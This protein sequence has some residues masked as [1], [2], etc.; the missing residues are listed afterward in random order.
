M[1]QNSHP[2][3]ATPAHPDLILESLQEREYSLTCG[4][5]HYQIKGYLR[6]SETAAEP[7]QQ[8]CFLHGTGFC[9]LTL[10]AMASLLPESWQLMFLDTPG[11]GGSTRPGKGMPDWQEMAQILGKS[12]HQQ[13]R[14]EPVVG[15]GHSMGGILLLLAAVQQPALFSRIV[16]LDPVLFS[17]K[18]IC[19]QRVM[20]TTGLWKFSKLVKTV[21]KRRCNWPDAQTMRDDLSRKSL[22]QQ[23]HPQALQD[24]IKGGTHAVPGGLQLNC[25]PGWESA[26]FGSFPRGLWKAVER[27]SIPVD[28]IIAR[29]SYNFISGSARRAAQLNV[30]ISCHDFGHSHCFPMEQPEETAALLINIIQNTGLRSAEKHTH[31]RL[32]SFLV[33]A[34]SNSMR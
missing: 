31:N 5:H 8:L 11:H 4:K 21:S 22:Y 7:K 27:T 32:K 29:K 25:N 18:I 26:I 2:D 15:V 33:R 9:G 1:I 10:A 13:S 19:W 24:F 34:L 6:P 3:I 14:G 16:L 30:N 12:M 20:R 28:I 23:W 17:R